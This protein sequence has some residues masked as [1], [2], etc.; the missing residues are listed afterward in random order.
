VRHVGHLPRIIK[1][2]C[3]I[4][5][6]TVPTCISPQETIVGNMYQLILPRI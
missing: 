3:C 6:L 1:Y 4:I 5:A 2:L